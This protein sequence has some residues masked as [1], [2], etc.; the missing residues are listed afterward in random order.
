MPKIRQASTADELLSAGSTSEKRHQEPE[1]E[2]KTSSQH[3][4]KESP[5]GSAREIEEL[6]TSV[7]ER[8]RE[9]PPLGRAREGERPT[10][11]A[12]G[13]TDQLPVPK[14][15]DDSGSLFSFN[16]FQGCY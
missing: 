2:K 9:S 4:R 13:K 5:A 1:R 7:R 11:N 16:I 3:Q 15:E 12:R 8:E 6:A 10:A 14:R